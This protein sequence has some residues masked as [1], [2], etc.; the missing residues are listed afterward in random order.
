MTADTYK[1]IAAAIIVLIL[2]L[3]TGL[4]IYQEKRIAGYME[5][6]DKI[7]NEIDIKNSEIN[8][9]MDKLESKQDQLLMQYNDMNVLMSNQMASRKIGEDFFKFMDSPESRQAYREQQRMVV[10]EIYG[11]L[12][13]NLGLNEEE[14]EEFRQLLLDKQMVTIEILV[15]LIKGNMTDEEKE[16]N[17]RK[18]VSMLDTADKNIRDFLEKDEYDIYLDYLDDLEYRNFIKDYKSYLAEADLDLDEDQEQRLFEEIRN[19]TVNFTFTEDLNLMELRKQG[20][21][22]QDNRYRLNRYLDEQAE[23]DQI[24]FDRSRDFLDE[25]QNEKL[26]EFQIMRRNMTELGFEV[27]TDMEIDKSK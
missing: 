21:L 16:E 6:L 14:T 8:K 1:K 5:Q 10:D 2:L 15:S 18:F 26:R 17:E 11:D 20:K 23:L 22:S 19:E 12:F 4:Y 13:T 7:E 3:F 25:I 27:T 24:I 9:V